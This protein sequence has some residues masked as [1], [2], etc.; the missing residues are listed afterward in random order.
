MRV[1]LFIP[2]SIG[3]VYYVRVCLSMVLQIPD[4]AIFSIIPTVG[5]CGL[6]TSVFQ[7]QV[8][9]RIKKGIRF[10]AQS[11][12][13]ASAN[14]LRRQINIF[15]RLPRAYIHATELFFLLF[16]QIPFT[17]MNRL[18]TSI[19]KK[20]SGKSWK[21]IF[22]QIKLHLWCKITKFRC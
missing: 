17:K 13:P 6:E 5:T 3:S 16:F 21:V 14:Q 2:P 9:V 8:V 12:T 4:H 15:H 20:N 11:V 22:Y 18:Q 7:L 19:M 1:W 10:T